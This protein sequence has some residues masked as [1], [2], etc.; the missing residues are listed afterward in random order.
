MMDRLEDIAYDL[1]EGDF[2]DIELVR[3]ADSEREIQKTLTMRLN[4]KANGVYRVTR[5]DE[6]AEGKLPDVRLHFTS[7]EQKAAIEVKIADKWSAN[8]LETALRNQLVE[9]YLRDS[10]CSAGCL[11]L[12]YHE[13]KEY[14]LAKDRN[15]RL[16]FSGF[17]AFL[18]EAAADIEKRKNVRVGVFGLDLVG[19]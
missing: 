8:D 9:G 12:V 1:K 13:K 2:S 6:V 19:G 18:Q 17:V 14:W 7:G 3:R 10:N 5:E 11:L 15:K 16:N 4:V